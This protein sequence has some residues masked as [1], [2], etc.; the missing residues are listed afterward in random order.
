MNDILQQTVIPRGDKLAP[1]DNVSGNNIEKRLEFY[2]RYVV[3]FFAKIV[4]GRNHKENPVFDRITMARLKHPT[5]V[6]LLNHFN[7]I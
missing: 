3:L 4:L 7:I 5:I 6:L 1:R 2:L